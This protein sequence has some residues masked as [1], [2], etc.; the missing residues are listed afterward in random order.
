[1]KEPKRDHNF[2]NHPYED[3]Y[4]YMVSSA[5][6]CP[7]RRRLGPRVCG[8]LELCYELSLVSTAAPWGIKT[9]FTYIYIC[10]ILPD[11]L[12]FWYMKCI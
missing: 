2:D 11:I 8:L 12:C 5:D 1:M 6:P 3:P 10:T 4:V 7:H 9:V